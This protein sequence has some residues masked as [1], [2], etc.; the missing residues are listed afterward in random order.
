MTP[1]IRTAIVLASL[2]G[3]AGCGDGGSP[4]I[5]PD[6]HGAVDATPLMMATEV[7]TVERLLAAGADPDEATPTGTTALMSAIAL[8]DRDIVAR[9]L[10]AGADPDLADG[11]G[12]TPLLIARAMKFESI[13]ELLRSHQAAPLPRPS[14]SASTLSTY[15]GTYRSEGT[16]VQIALDRGRLLLVEAAGP[17]GIYEI[18]LIPLDETTFYREYDPAAMPFRFDADADGSVIGLGSVDGR[19]R[20]ERV[21]V[22]E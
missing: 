16:E 14:I 10:E 15:V 9:L 19:S 21:Q 4:P 17:S 18:E 3:A 1:A 6:A 2:L 12:R 7:A 20:F 13:E 11:I 22:V 5:D 8:G